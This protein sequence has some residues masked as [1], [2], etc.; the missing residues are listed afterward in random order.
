[1]KKLIIILF[2]VSIA[3]LSCKKVDNS[4]NGINGS[5][6]KLTVNEKLVYRKPVTPDEIH[7]VENLNKVTIVFKELYKD[8]YNL[9]LVN[10]AIYSKVFKDESVL[11]KDLIYPEAGV[12]ATDQRFINLAKKLN[13][14]LTTFNN[15]FWNQVNKMG[16]PAFS[17]FLQSIKPDDY[18]YELSNKK[19]AQTYSYGDISIYFPYSENF[20]YQ[21]D[22]IQSDPDNPQITTI[23]AATADADE[24]VGFAPYLDMNGVLQYQ[25]IIVNDDYAYEHPT[26]IIGINSLEPYGDATPPSTY[27]LFDPSDSIDIPNFNIGRSVHMVFIGDVKVTHQYDHLISFTGNGGA[28]EIRFTRSDGYLKLVD[29]QV[30]ADNYIVDG[31]PYVTR[32][33]IRNGNWVEWS[34]SWDTDWEPNNKEQYFAIYEDDNRNTGTITASIKTTLKLDTIVTIE[35]NI[36]VSLTYKSDD[37]VI[38]QTNMKY[39]SFFA[40]NRVDLEG[41]M[42]NGWPVYDKNGGVSFTLWDKTI[43]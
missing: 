28:S 17:S 32:K 37:A 20:S 9:R 2:I 31:P 26:Q 5:N 35:G 27:G 23:A 14:N 22:W 8:S 38:R 15:N 42:H 12:L 7:L 41:E 30:T 13:V 11:L 40:L 34:A 25:D 16:D 10:A 6:G 21:I 43:Y 36:G 3:I 29:G 33:N 24:G 39:S 4:G 18:V 1:M 19:S